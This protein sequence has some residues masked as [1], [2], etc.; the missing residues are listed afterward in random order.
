MLLISCPHCGPRAEDEFVH[1]GDAGGVRPADPA[2]L[3]DAAWTAYLYFR[4]NPVGAHQEYWFH[5]FGC[6]RW[7]VLRRDTLTHQILAVALP[8]AAMPDEP[9]P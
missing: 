2:S 5:R 1:G 7:L 4:D 9:P 6:R 3:D 8:G